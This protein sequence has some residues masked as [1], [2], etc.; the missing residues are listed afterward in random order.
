MLCYLYSHWR[1]LFLDCSIYRIYLF[2][3]WTP[4]MSHQLGSGTLQHSLS[5]NNCLKFLHDSSSML[6]SWEVGGSWHVN[7]C[8]DKS[9]AHPSVLPCIFSHQYHTNRILLALH[10]VKEW[11]MSFHSVSCK[12]TSWTQSLGAVS[13]WLLIGFSEASRI[14]D[15]DM[16]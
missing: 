6:L 14:I 10:V 11:I 15:T 2:P 16:G 1:K 13:S 4:A 7:C 12:S 8:Y 5:C 3:S 9:L